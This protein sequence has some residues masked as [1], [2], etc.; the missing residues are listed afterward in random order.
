[1]NTI[2][3]QVGEE[4]PLRPT[5]PVLCQ[6]DEHL[7]SLKVLAGQVA[8]DFNNSLAPILGYISL[9]RDEAAQET[10]IHSYAIALEG[11][12]RKVGKNIDN[13]LL[14][15]RP[16]RRFRPELFNFKELLGEALEE[17]RNTAPGEDRIQ[18]ASHIEPLKLWG[19]RTQWRQVC[20]QILN[21][22]AQA[23][24]N[25]GNLSV[26]LKSTILP[27][28][29]CESLGLPTREVLLL[30]FVDTGIG[31]NEQVLARAYDPF[32]TT[33][34]KSQGQGLGLTIVHS[35]VYLHNGQVILE[36][37]PEKGTT[38][39]IWVPARITMPPERIG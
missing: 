37:S 3:S 35:V 18:V 38:V 17:W 10:N 21:N 6:R 27:P 33:R 30:S 13:L 11:V 2:N 22:A 7:E 19:D 34:P 23:M 16:Q 4:G 12:V 1:M 14:A 32:F 9:I 8:H 15:T 5:S 29:E 20:L 39:T 25:G 31:M 24:P 36:S 26:I 28:E